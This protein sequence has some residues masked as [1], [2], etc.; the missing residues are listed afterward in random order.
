MTPDLVSLVQKIAIWAIPVLFAI[1]LHEVAHGWAARALGD[2]TAEMLGRLSLNPIKHIDPMGT[3][4]VPAIMLMLGGFLFGW[5]KPV[6]IGIRNLRNPRR[7]FALVALAG[8]MSNLVMAIGWGILAKIAVNMNPQEGVWLGILLMARAGIIINLVLMV[9][10]LLPFPPLDG[11]RVLAGLLPEPQA[12]VLDR[13]EPYGL[14]VLIVLMVT[15]ILSKIMI[16]PLVLSGNAL[17]TVLGLQG[18][19]LF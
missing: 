10:N 6:P 11:G 14:V 12:R 13:I 3:L 17:L 7:D 19:P 9:L 5:A 15:G 8:P 4:L 16:W 2:R 1:T 18:L